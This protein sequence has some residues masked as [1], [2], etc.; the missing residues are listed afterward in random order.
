VS[1]KSVQR[2]K[3]KV[4]HLLAPGNHDP[5]L[6]VRDALNALLFG[7]ARYFSK[8]DLSGQ[9]WVRDAG[10]KLSPIATS[11]APRWNSV[12]GRFPAADQFDLSSAVRRCRLQW[13]T[14]D[15]SILGKYAAKWMKKHQPQWEG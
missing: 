8:T 12:L 2:L 7:W 6:D 14:Y 15:A 1:K 11:A 5:W 9:R 10:G 4:A 3:T 13:G